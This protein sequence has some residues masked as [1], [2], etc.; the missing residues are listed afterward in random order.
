MSPVYDPRT[1]ME[2]LPA[3]ECWTRLGSAP[4]ARIALV[5]DDAPEIFPVNI[6]VTDTPSVVFRTAP[7]TKLAGVGEHMNAAVEVDGIEP[8]SQQ[9]WSVM[10]VGPARQV[11]EPELVRRF[12]DL[13]LDPWV[14]G[15]KTIW[16]QVTPERVTGR[17][18]NPRQG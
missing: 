4:I 12:E 15:H 11:H 18:I 16:V 8:D 3:A 1:W 5:I 10:A 14:Q 7:G 6:A 17:R 9:G 2:V 13:G